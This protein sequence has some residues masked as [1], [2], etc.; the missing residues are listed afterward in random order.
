MMDTIAIEGGS[1]VEESGR[2]GVV[3]GVGA[4]WSGARERS[5]M[6]EHK[7]TQEGKG[8]R[9]GRPWGTRESGDNKKKEMRER[10]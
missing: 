3:R 5:R 6:G 2:E 4:A 9:G 8:G 1:L 7:K 10:E